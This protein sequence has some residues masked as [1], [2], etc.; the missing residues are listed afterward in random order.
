MRQET[1][2]RVAIVLAGVFIGALGFV[3]GVERGARVGLETEI[4]QAVEDLHDMVGPCTTDADCAAKCGG[5]GGPAP[6]M[7]AFR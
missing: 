4:A 3:A 7:V 1:H 2:Q 6:A 5:D